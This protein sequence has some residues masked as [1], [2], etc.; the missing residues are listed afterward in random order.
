MVLLVAVLPGAHE[1]VVAVDGHVEGAG[2]VGE[3]VQRASRRQVEPG[4]VPVARHQPVPHGA[5]VQREP[6]VRA[7]IVD[8]PRPVV[9]PEDDHR[10]AAHLREQLA[11]LGQLGQRSGPDPHVTNVIEVG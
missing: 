11:G 5:P 2:V 8:R 9:V 10:H 1:D 4:V 6:H 3:E 7:P